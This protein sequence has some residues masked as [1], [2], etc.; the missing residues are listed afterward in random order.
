[1]RIWIEPAALEEIKTLPGYWRQRVRRVVK[2][3]SS[4]PRPHDSRILNMPEGVLHA[5][6]ELRRI[7]LDKLRIVYVL[8]QKWDIATVIAVRK[9]PPYD[10]DDLPELLAG[11]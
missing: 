3:L 2:A 4:Q 6:L 8:D 5:K 10:Y 1:M 11:L 9:R 7:R